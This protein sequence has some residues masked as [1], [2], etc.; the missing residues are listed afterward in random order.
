[1]EHQPAWCVTLGQQQHSVPVRCLPRAALVDDRAVGNTEEEI[2]CPIRETHPEASIV[3]NRDAPSF[4][5]VPII[6]KAVQQRLA[7]QR[8]GIDRMLRRRGWV[9]GRHTQ[10]LIAEGCRH[11][12]RAREEGLLEP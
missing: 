12:A 6:A 4:R 10:L 2:Q 1:M 9:G 3:A 7:P 8:M 11:R 5:R